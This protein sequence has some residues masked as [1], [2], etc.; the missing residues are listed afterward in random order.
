MSSRTDTRNRKAVLIKLIQVGIQDNNATPEVKF[1]TTV[2]DCAKV[3]INMKNSYSKQKFESQIT[4]NNKCSKQ[5][6]GSE[7]KPGSFKN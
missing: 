3:C 5:S 7:S 2:V 6:T 4:R 1:W